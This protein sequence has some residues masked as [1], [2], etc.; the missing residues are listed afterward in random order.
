MTTAD[1]AQ[2][3]SGA[4]RLKALLDDF[5]LHSDDADLRGRVRSLLP[6]LHE[7]RALGKALMPEDVDL[8]GRDRILRYL[9]RYPLTVI[10]GD[11]LLL[12]SG[13]GDWARRVRELRVQLGWRVFSGV[14]FKEMAA[15]VPEVAQELAAALNV[16]PATLRADHYILTGTEQDREAAHRWHL[17]NSIRKLK[18]VSVKE[19]ILRYLRE[20][21]G[22]PVT[23][24][25]LRYLAGNKSD[26]PRRTREL[27]TE[28]GW[29]VFTSMQGRPDLAIGTYV[30]DEDRQAPPHDRR[31]KDE[32]RIEVLERDGF[33]CTACGWTREQAQPDDPRRRL[34][35]HHLIEHAAKGSNNAENLITLCNVDHDRVHAGRLEYVDGKWRAVE[36]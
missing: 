11:E 22:Q 33:A 23:S 13:I 20:N 7:L 21:V 32:V 29:P 15:D 14:T 2:G 18:R 19:K 28:G 6:V 17:L 5:A 25:E 36:N 27:R 12:I 30:L 34:E 16:D 35:P 3:R 24:E 1:E 31:I 4:E 26:W 8:S 10:E 9:R